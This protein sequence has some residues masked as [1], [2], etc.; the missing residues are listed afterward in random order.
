MQDRRGE[1]RMVDRVGE[2]LCF[3]AKA[4]V[5]LIHDAV[6]A[7]ERTIQKVARIEL[8]AGLSCQDFEGAP[9]GWLIN[10]RCPGQGLAAT[11]YDKVVVIAN[12]LLFQLIET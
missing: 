8:D 2:M 5:L 11:I 7:G 9:R 4:S 12:R 3:E 1:V 10:A 6:M